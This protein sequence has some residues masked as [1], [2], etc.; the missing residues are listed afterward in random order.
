VSC[1]DWRTLLARR[2]AR[3]D[4]DPDGW[5]AARRHLAGCAAC[6]A[7]ALAWDPTLLFLQLPAPR[8]EAGDVA[9]MQE[10]VAALVRAGRVDP[11][12]ARRLRAARPAGRWR[13]VAAAAV[14]ALAALVVEPVRRPDAA[15]ADELAAF[16]A[17]WLP[18]LAVPAVLEEIESPEARVYQIP[19]EG[20]SVVMVVDASLDV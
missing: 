5:A 8:V 16:D 2:E 10:A 3:P 7:E 4:D 12:K 19:A 1:P 6:R 11:R 20:L 15:P 18:A 9:A 17:D 14:L 13:S